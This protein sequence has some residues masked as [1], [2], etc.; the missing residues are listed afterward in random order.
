MRGFRLISLGLFMLLSLGSFPAT[1]QVTVSKLSDL[2]FGSMMLP[3]IAGRSVT[4]NA[5]T[6]NRTQTASLTVLPASR[7]PFGRAVFRV[8]G[9]VG[10]TFSVSLPGTIY[11]T[12]PGSTNVT[13]TNWTSTVANSNIPAAGFTDVGYGAQMNVPNTATAEG[14]YSGTFTITVTWP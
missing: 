13:V 2:Q 9:P 8:S 7:R 10:Q 5:S 6:G 3:T 11:L 14:V 12:S 4:I 1:S